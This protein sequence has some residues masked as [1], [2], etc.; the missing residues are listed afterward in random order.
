VPKLLIFAP[1]EKVIIDQQ[2]NLTLVA[3]LQSLQI[4]LP[5]REIPE[6]GTAAFGWSVLSLWYREPGDEHRGFEQS[7]ELLGP[8]GSIVGQARSPFRLEKPSHR[9]TTLFRG[10]PVGRGGGDYSL[11]L[12]LREDVEGAERKEVATFPLRVEVK[13]PSKTE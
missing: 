5:P 13:P 12:Y 4:H 7:I 11:K 1:C 2:Q 6:K 8:D 9:Q 3:V 10:F